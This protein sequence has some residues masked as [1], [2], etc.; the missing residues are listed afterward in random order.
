[1][2]PLYQS[3]EYNARIQSRLFLGAGGMVFVKAR[4][5]I[6]Y[7]VGVVR[8]TMSALDGMTYNRRQECS[9]GYR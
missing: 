3:K 2:I 7:D 1:M 9:Q 5:G 6:R 8:M 4:K